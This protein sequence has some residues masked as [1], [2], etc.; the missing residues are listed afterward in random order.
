[1][2]AQL[3]CGS[4]NLCCKLLNVPDIS[5]PALMTCWHTTLHGGCLV[6]DKKSSDPSLK[7]CEQ[8]YCVWL[9]SQTLDDEAKRGSRAMRP[10]QCHVLLGPF[11]RD[12]PKLLYV[13][14]DPNYKSAWREPGVTA[15]L[16]EI[17]AK[18]ASACIVVGDHHFNYMPSL[19]PPVN[20][21]F[22]VVGSEP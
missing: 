5:K 4:C 13:H 18:G 19:P 22:E 9:A 12:N 15:Y 11:D 1:M 16:D 6:H 10:D 2:G 14:V 20:I 21:E 17:C 8:F 7:A 3:G